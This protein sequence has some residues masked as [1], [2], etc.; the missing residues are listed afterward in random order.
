MQPGKHTLLHIPRGAAPNGTLLR[1]MADTRQLGARCTDIYFQEVNITGAWAEIEQA[2]GF[3]FRADEVGCER[4]ARKMK[5]GKVDLK[6]VHGCTSK[7]ARYI[8]FYVQHLGSIGLTVGG[9]LGE[10]DHAAEEIPSEECARRASLDEAR[11]SDG[12]PGAAADFGS[13]AETNLA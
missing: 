2:G 4:E 10:D 3:R 12:K 8:N 1:V 13:F 6:I 5:L 11:G 7:G 9:L